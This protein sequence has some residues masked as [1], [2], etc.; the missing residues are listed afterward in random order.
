MVGRG[1]CN[2]LIILLTA[3]LSTLQNGCSNTR[4]P[5]NSKVLPRGLYEPVSGP[6][7]RPPMDGDMCEDEAPAPLEEERGE[8]S[9]HGQ[10]LEEDRD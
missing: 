4:S 5:L 3:L 10:R 7:E 6:M 9:S 2:R 1:T 8:S